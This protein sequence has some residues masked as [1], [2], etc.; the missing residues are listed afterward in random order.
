MREEPGADPKDPEEEFTHRRL[1]IPNELW[2]RILK[3][4][5]STG[6]NYKDLVIVLLED[7]VTVRAWEGERFGVPDKPSVSPLTKVLIELGQKIVG[8]AFL[9]SVPGKG[10]TITW[11]EKAYVVQER[12]WAL[13]TRKATAYLRVKPWK[14]PKLEGDQ[15]R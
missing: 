12:A 13:G 11:R 7:G 8:T 15:D 2:G 4:A 1:A 14:G 10:E 3:L 5:D 9:T 6:L